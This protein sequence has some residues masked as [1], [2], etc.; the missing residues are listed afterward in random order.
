M[1]GILLLIAII[2]F[3][4]ESESGVEVPFATKTSDPKVQMVKLTE[5]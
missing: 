4:V 5:S 1:H 2:V 3:P